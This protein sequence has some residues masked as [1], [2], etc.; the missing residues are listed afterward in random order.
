[1]IEFIGRIDRQV[2]IRGVRIEIGEVEANI[3]N[4]PMVKE[5]LVTLWGE[6]INKK[7]VA[8]VILKQNIEQNNSDITKNLREYLKEFVHPAALPDS[9]TI[10]S[11]FPINING[12]I[13]LNALPAPIFSSVKDIIEPRFYE[14]DVIKQIFVE[15]IG[16]SNI[17]IFETFVELGGH[18]L[19][20]TQIGARINQIFSSNLS[21]KDIFENTT[22]ASLASLVLTKKNSIE[23]ENIRISYSRKGALTSSQERLWYLYQLDPT[24]ISYNLPL[25]IKLVGSLNYDILSQSLNYIIERHETFRTI[26]G[27]EKGEAYQKVL[28]QEKINIKPE[29]V[30]Y[31]SLHE[32]MTQ[33]CQKPFILEDAPPVRITLYK[34]SD[35]EHCLLFI[36]HN[37][38]TDAWSEGVII[39]ELFQI[40]QQLQSKNIYPILPEI[41]YQIIDIANHYKNYPHNSLERASSLNFWKNNFDGYNEFE[42]PSEYPRPDIMSYKGKRISYVFDKHNWQDLNNFAKSQEVTMFMFILSILKILIYKYTSVNDIAVGIALA[43]RNKHYLEKVTGFFVNTLP[44]RSQFLPSTT[45]K[46]FLQDIKNNCLDVYKYQDIEFEQI[47]EV[48]KP[49]RRLNKNPL[50][51]IMLVLQNADE[52]LL[53]MVENLEISKINVDTETSMFDMVWNFQELDGK[54]CLNLDFSTELYKEATIWRVIKNYEV[55]VSELLVNFNK[56]IANIRSI[57]TDEMNFINS[58]TKGKI[59]EVSN[60]TIGEW[61]NNSCIINNKNIAIETNEVSINYEQMNELSSHLANY[62]ISTIGSHDYPE[63]K[64]IG[65]LLNR[66]HNLIIAIYGIVK[67]CYCYVPLDPDYPQERLEYM[68]GDAKLDAII[69]DQNLLNLAQSI[70]SINKQSLIDINSATD[71][72][73]IRSSNHHYQYNQNNLAYILY[74]SGSTGSPKGVMITHANLVNFCQDMIERLKFKDIDIFMSITT[75]S[76]DIFGLEYLCTLLSG[77]KIFLCSQDIARNPVSLVNLFNELQPSKMQATPTMWSMIIDHIFPTQKFLA[78]CGGEN[79]PQSLLYKFQNKNINIWNLYGPTETT[80]WSTAANLSSEQYAHIGTPINNTEC[81]ILD[82]DLS[83]VPVGV[84]GKLFISGAGVAKGYWN[85]NDLTSKQF[86]SIDNIDNR[87]LYNTGDLAKLDDIGNFICG[88]RTDFQIKI[89]GNRVELGE[90]EYHLSLHDKVKEIICHMTTNGV[91]DIIAAYIIPVS[92]S[93]APN[94][95]ELR[96]FLEKKI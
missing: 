38:I 12:K 66:S 30:D 51:Q 29:L 48:V 10:V 56:P 32:H 2:K 8:Y 16:N 40:Y 21:T 52:E 95:E 77:A 73:T 49:I 37:I 25:A 84:Y 82:D 55:I 71:A 41:Q 34:M 23:T 36:K 33:L 11:S 78:L 44:I 43:G 70:S 75:I 83:I 93:D 90:I 96:S 67:A 45:F 88:G 18:S 13:D 59:V 20:A 4:H 7:L 63:I 19:S 9:F 65:I 53:P 17:G 57:S 6:E 60:I 85:K 61:L 1:M 35:T 87:I 27:A 89:R 3:N 69:Y 54:L 68:V 94:D 31:M 39:K 74:T 15:I 86:L 92:S 28:S 47:V 26:F 72:N 76:F 5:S 50:F 64:R 14:E 58:K 42:F 91:N 24:N 22:I 79:L 81:Y 62:L 80:I 46:Q